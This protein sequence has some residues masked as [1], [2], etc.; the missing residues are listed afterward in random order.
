[1]KIW[2]IIKIR[3][4]NPLY[5]FKIQ[6]YDYGIKLKRNKDTY[7]KVKLGVDDKTELIELYIKTKKNISD[8]FAERFILL[9][10]LSVRNATPSFIP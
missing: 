6:M 9:T 3:I 1:M 8:R 7:I 5:K 4:I 2:L 10:T